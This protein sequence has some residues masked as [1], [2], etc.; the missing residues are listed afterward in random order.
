MKKK[1]FT[2]IEVIVTIGLLVLVGVLIASNMSAVFSNQEE[3]NMEDFK[4]NLEEAACVYIDLSD[5]GIKEEKN[6]C[7]SNTNGCLINTNVLINKGLLDEEYKNPQTGKSL[8]DHG[9][10]IQIKYDYGEKK[11]IFRE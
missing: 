2:L 7:K 8:K 6:K 5:L 9:Y 11:C 1:G 10:D 3:K 4:K